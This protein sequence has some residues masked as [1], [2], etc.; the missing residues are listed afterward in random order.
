MKDL[1][2]EMDKNMRDIFK[3]MGDLF[4]PE[5]SLTEKLM[6]CKTDKDISDVVFDNLEFLNRNPRMFTLVNDARKR[7]KGLFKV[8]VDAWGLTKLN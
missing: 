8:Q 1:F 6:N 4:R 7:V 2:D 3:E 5:D